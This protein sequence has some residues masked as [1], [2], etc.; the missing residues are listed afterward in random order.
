MSSSP[1]IN[2]RVGWPYRI[3]LLAVLAIAFAVRVPD[4]GLGGYEPDEIWTSEIAMGRGSSHLEWPRNQVIALP[5]VYDSSRAAPTWQVWN[6]LTM[7]H[8]PLYYV[9]LRLWM[10]LF[11]LGD[12]AERSL[13]LVLSLLAVA[14]FFDAV[15][16]TSGPR[17]ALWAALLMALA[18]PQVEYARQARNYA[19]LTL[20]AVGAVDALLRIELLGLSKRRVAALG[21]LIL[22][23]LLTHYFC[24]GL[25]AALF[26]YACI[27]LRGSARRWTV[28]AFV[29]AAV[30]CAIVWGPFFWQQR[31][32]FTKS[33]DAVLW[34]NENDPRHLWWTLQRFLLLP[35]TL[36]CET[37]SASWH[38]P[39]MIA[40]SAV[41]GAPVLLT[42]RRPDLLVWT[43]WLLS[44][45]ALLLLLD[46]TRHTTHL[47]WTRYTLLAGPGVYALLS[48]L[49][50]TI[51]P[52]RRWS[53]LARHI[54]P[55]LAA[56]ACIA[57]VPRAYPPG[58]AGEPLAI[59]RAFQRWVHADD[60][61]V[62]VGTGNQAWSAG[63]NC[64]LVER[65]FDPK[66]SRVALLDRPAAGE[67]LQ[68]LQHQRRLIVFTKTEDARQFLP[69]MVA[70]DMA[71]CP[72]RALVWIMA[73]GP[74]R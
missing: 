9:L 8:P 18:V 27:R 25:L 74:Q 72:G 4:L 43:L 6:H 3:L 26:A 65:Y 61:I 28:A 50:L 12:S 38:V 66:P 30:V 69:G 23:T 32:L 70:L 35:A 2:A 41:F 47:Q 60:A 46:L 55:A 71:N 59:R 42:R 56:A 34:L 11:G 63:E 73:P 68:Q 52:T 49:T 36:L 16:L 1:A 29:M 20:V 51:G 19:M 31:Q 57:T 22:A 13:S 64:L 37:I 45:P 62:F 67:T 39:A 17:A 54:V 10:N 44:T 14:V 40:G 21:A 15:R 7:T 48:G 24:I 5:V 53:A 58:N 33:D